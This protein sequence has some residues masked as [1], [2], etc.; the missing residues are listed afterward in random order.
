MENKSNV[1]KKWIY[2]FVFAVA[3]IL[4]YKTLD[5]FN[6]I[7]AWIQNLLNVLMPFIIGIL[8]AYLFYIPSRKFEGIYKKSKVKILSKRARGFGVFSVYIIA[9]II[10]TLA[11]NFVLPAISES[12]MELINNLPGYYNNAMN[13]VDNLPEDNILRYIDIKGYIQEL[14]NINLSEF[15]NMNTLRDYAQ[16]VINVATGLFDFFVALIVSIYILLER[17]Q[18]IDFARRLCSVIFK[19]KVYNNLGKYFATTNEVFFKFLYGQILDGVL[20]GVLTSIL[21]SIMGVK[22]GILLGVMIGMLNLIPYF[23]AIIAI[24]IA[25]IITI[26]TGGIGQAIWLAVLATILQQIDANIINPRILGNALKISPLLVIFA[27]TV[28]GAYFGVLGMF[29]G[30]PVV[31]VIKILIEDYIEHKNTVEK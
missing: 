27:V 29:L 2:W 3:V 31:T 5:N 24:I 4:V 15:I 16:G 12:I 17:R 30:V 14:Q 28:G 22:Y 1:W 19:D 21:F 6:D 20:V 26:F 11:I 8:I 7:K 10:C 23:G 9:I 13:S 25:I 18:I